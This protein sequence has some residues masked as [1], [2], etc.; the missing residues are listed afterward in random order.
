MT[1]ISKRI[2]AGLALAPLAVLST[3][4]TTL[5][6]AP[7]VPAAV[8]AEVVPAPAEVVV[9][10]IRSELQVPASSTSSSQTSRGPLVGVKAVQAAS[11]RG[12]PATALAAYQR[13]AAV[14]DAADSGCHL[15]WQL[16]AAIG[17]VESD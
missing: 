4:W 3:A 9:P 13:A 7:S 2:K 5:L 17:R 6:V 12:I 15:P 14:M 11:I 8:V 16:L 10:E 1:T